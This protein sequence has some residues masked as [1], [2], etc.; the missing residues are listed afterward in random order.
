MDKLAQ[1]R[2]FF[3]KLREKTNITG[4]ILESLNP[5]FQ[6]MMDRLRATDERIREQAIGSK[7]LVRASRS[8]VRRRDYLSAAVNFSAFHER[9]RLIAAILEKFRNT[10]DLKHYEFLLD[11]FDDEQKEQ[12]FG[13]DPD[14][15][16]DVE[17]NEANDMV[18]SASIRKQAGLSDWWFKITDPITDVAHNLATQRGIAMRALE[19]RFSIAFLDQL[20]TA[21]NI[22]ADKTEQF[23]N[24][25]LNT[26]KKLATALAKKNV[27]QYLDI[28]KEYVKRFARYHEMFTKYY[29]ANIV[30]LKKQYEQLVEA[31][32]QAEEAKAKKFEEGQIAPETN[33]PSVES[34]YGGQ[35]SIMQ[36][37]G[38]APPRVTNPPKP[39]PSAPTGEPVPFTNEPEELTYDP[40]LPIDLKKKKSHF[41]AK[42]EKYASM[43]KPDLMILEI[44]RYSSELEDSSPEKSMKLLAIAEGLIEDKKAGILDMFKK[45]EEPKE[46]Q[47]APKT[48]TKREAPP[49]V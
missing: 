34:L 46:Q 1:E 44:L 14:K 18:I 45:K 30:P 36:M 17:E 21:S 4:K 5:E 40:N 23:L 11:Q 22:M 19:K 2:G 3:N 49:L 7:D 32:R 48:E 25:F 6:K 10:V 15:K 28:A 38:E 42:I 27:K 35:P 31:K 47:V 16:L 33:K 20:K 13:Y 29:Q 43:N 37:P 41:I 8:L 39:K 12:L 24:F 9:T 26:F